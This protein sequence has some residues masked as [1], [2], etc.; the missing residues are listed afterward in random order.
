MTLNNYIATMRAI[1]HWSVGVHRSSQVKPY[2]NIPHSHPTRWTDLRVSASA[3][4]RRLHRQL[5]PYVSSAR[6][7]RHRPNT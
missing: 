7:R 1:S 2:A 5:D 6:L 3:K 4:Q